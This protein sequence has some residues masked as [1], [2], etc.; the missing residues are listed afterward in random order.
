MCIWPIPDHISCIGV[1]T[2]ISYSQVAGLVQKIIS[3][4]D[5]TS[6]YIA[7][8]RRSNCN[9]HM[10]SMHVTHPVYDWEFANLVKCECPYL[11]KLSC[12][13]IPLSWL[14][15]LLVRK[16]ATCRCH[17]RDALPYDVLVSC[18]DPFQMYRIL[19]TLWLV[20]CGVWWKH[21]P[22]K[23]CVG[24]NSAINLPLVLCKGDYLLSCSLV[25]GLSPLTRRAWEQG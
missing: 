11:H 15:H 25:P 7:V 24:W 16:I 22:Y 18:L 13:R 23:T 19:K 5:G 14:P 10:L 12:L 21:H 8:L 4:S 2:A 6:L 20:R 17:L 3:S 1:G 9:C